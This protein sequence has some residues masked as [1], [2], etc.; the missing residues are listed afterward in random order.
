[1]AKDKTK[2]KKN[3]VKQKYTIKKT[4][5]CSYCSK[6]FNRRD[7][8]V[9]HEK[10]H[11]SKTE[12]VLKCKHCGKSFAQKGNMTRHEVHCATL[13][14]ECKICPYRKRF[15]LRQSL[16]RHIKLEHKKDDREKVEEFLQSLD[17]TTPFSCKKCNKKFASARGL[18]DHEEN[19]KKACDAI[20]RLTCDYCGKAFKTT[21]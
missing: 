3:I 13:I 11:L 2:E 8:V 18:K 10:I 9:T 17:E 5:S 6:T 1:M 21:T 15:E 4:F 14:F 19:K 16:L 7:T 12:A 20:R